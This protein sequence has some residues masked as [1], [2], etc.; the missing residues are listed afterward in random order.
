MVV[1]SEFSRHAGQ[2]MHPLMTLTDGG[3]SV[4]LRF[5]GV[6]ETKGV[7]SNAPMNDPRIHS[8]KLP[9]MAICMGGSRAIFG[10]RYLWDLRIAE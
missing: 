2:V 6:E 10:R 7:A 1:S 9:C 8:N 5:S 3:I 4:M